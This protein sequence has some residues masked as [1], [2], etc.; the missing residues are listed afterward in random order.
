MNK[1][2]AIVY[3][4]K[5]GNTKSMANAIKEGALEAGAEVTMYKAYNFNKEVI[6]EYEKIAFG[7]PAMGGEELE[8]TEFSP[9]FNEI[10]DSL[11]GKT[12]FLFGSYGWGSGKWMRKWEDEIT[13]LGLTLFR[14]S[15]ICMEKPDENTLNLCKEA[16]IVLAK[17]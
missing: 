4:S 10:K 11:N 16:G 1:K 14:E 9:M 6:K 7:C 5:T 13:F 15:I 8:E 2:I 12:F 3:W 17:L